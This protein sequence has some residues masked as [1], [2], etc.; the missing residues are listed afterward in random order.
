MEKLLVITEK[1][2][3]ARTIAEVLN[4]KTK[5]EGCIYNDKYII[6]W[7][8]G[9]LLQLKDPQDYDPELKKWNAESLPIIPEKWGYKPPVPRKGKD[10]KPD[11]GAKK[12]LANLKT[13]MTRSDVRG[14]ICA[15]DAGREGELIFRN[16]Y[17]WTGSHKPVKRLWTSSLEESALRKGFKEMK[18]SDNYDNLYAAALCRSQADWLVGINGTRF[19]SLMKNTPGNPWSVGRVQTP[20]L[21]LIVERTKEIREFQAVPFYTIRNSYDDGPFMLESERYDSEDE[22]RKDA[23]AIEGKSLTITKLETKHVKKNPPPLYSLNNLQREANKRYGFTADNTLKILQGLYEKKLVTYPRTDAN[24]ITDDMGETYMN[25]LRGLTKKMAN[26]YKPGRPVAAVINNAKVTDHHALLV[27][28]TYIRNMEQSHGTSEDLILKLIASRMLVALGATYEYD[29]TKI[30]ASEGSVVLSGSGTKVTNGGWLELDRQLMPRKGGKQA[31]NGGNV[32]PAYVSKG[33]KLQGGKTEV[34]SGQTTP[35]K[36]YTEDTLLAAMDKAGASEMDKDVERKGIGTSATRA[37]IIERLIT[38]GYVFRDKQGK[39]T[40][41]VSTDKGDELISLV[42]K[43]LKTPSLTATWENRLLDVERGKED[44]KAFMQDITGY[45]M[46]IVSEKDKLPKKMSSTARPLGK[47]FYCGGDIV[48]TD[49]KAECQQCHTKL[50]RAAQFLNGKALTDDEVVKLMGGEKILRN[51]V[52]K[53]GKPYQAY[54]RLNDKP[55]EN[56]W[57]GLA[58]EFANNRENN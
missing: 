23:A 32:F 12:Q 30:E 5:G 44:P 47:C 2:S 13:L 6:S 8:F 57:A 51:L 16:V 33:Y 42:N 56:G 34:Y 20:T 4:A 1:P 54:L 29:E 14:I 9:H 22:A 49:S 24:Y 31:G 15:T 18:T 3:V 41:L 55:N 39:T 43:D 21:S 50:Y 27:T 35:P 38:V 26:G 46:E 19:Y 37:E 36:P 28:E 58:M 48:S 10:G 40:Y 53:A 52:S 17:N 25:L 7:C 45:V 11:D